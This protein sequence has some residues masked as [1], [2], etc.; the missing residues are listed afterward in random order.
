MIIQS[1]FLFAC[2]GGVK[3]NDGVDLSPVMTMAVMTPIGPW[4]NGSVY[5]MDLSD[6]HFAG[7]APCHHPDAVQQEQRS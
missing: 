3:I 1:S 4:N 2:N 6:W 5:L 7:N